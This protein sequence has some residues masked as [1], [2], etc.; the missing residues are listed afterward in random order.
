[1]GHRVGNQKVEPNQDTVNKI[2][3]AERPTT[4]KQ[5][6][7]FIG[8]I[9]YYRKFIPNFAAIAVPLTDL[10]RKGS[11]N[12]LPWEDVHQRSFDSLRRYIANPPIM[13]L[14]DLSEPFVL[15]TDAS[16]QGLGAILLQEVEG[17]KHPIMF[18]SRKLLPRE[19]NY[20]TI[21]HECLAVVW[22]IQKF[23][24]YLYGR[25]FV[26]ETDQPPLQH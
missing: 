22:G 17:V 6:R 26:L 1:M 15:Q 2:L 13:R 21:E 20:S 16:N 11:P 7:S 23:Q 8:L 5:L 3:L 24:V 9:S 14:P 25:Q 12:D 19:Q 10:T 4:K 18:A